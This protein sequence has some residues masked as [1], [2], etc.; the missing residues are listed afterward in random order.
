MAGRLSEQGAGDTP[1]AVCVKVWLAWARWSIFPIGKI[2]LQF[3]VKW[4][5]SSRAVRSGLK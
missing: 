1:A 2:T 3:G 5:D 4:L